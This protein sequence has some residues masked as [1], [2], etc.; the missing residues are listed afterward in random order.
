MEMVIQVIVGGIVA[1]Q[2]VGKMLQAKIAR[3]IF[4]G[5]IDFTLLF[6]ATAKKNWVKAAAQNFHR[7]PP[8]SQINHHTAKSTMAGGVEIKCFRD[9]CILCVGVP[10][11]L[12]GAGTAPARKKMI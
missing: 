7:T 4:F 11:T 2:F 10:S 12:C 6:G 5:N 1:R 9:P 3:A 8:P